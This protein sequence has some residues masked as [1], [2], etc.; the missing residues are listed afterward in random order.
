MAEAAIKSW[1]K[2]GVRLRAR[3]QIGGYPAWY[4]FSRRHRE[5]GNINLEG[6]TGKEKNTADA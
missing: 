1:T 5:I 4:F 3:G 6:A 2:A